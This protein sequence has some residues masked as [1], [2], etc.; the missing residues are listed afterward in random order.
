MGAQN[1]EDWESLSLVFSE[2]LLKPAGFIV[3]SSTG[4]EVFSM[5]KFFFTHLL[6]S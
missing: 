5:Q 2:I 4:A 6:R 3:I 1:S